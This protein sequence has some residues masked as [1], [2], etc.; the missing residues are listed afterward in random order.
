MRR[1]VYQAI[2]I[3]EGVE[4]SV[5]GDLITAKG[6][7]GEVRKKINLSGLDVKVEGSKFRVGCKRS[8]RN[9]KKMINTIEAHMKNMIEGVQK[10]FEYNLKICFSHF[11]I[12]T[13]IRGGEMIIKNFLGER[14]NRKAILPEGAEVKVNKEIIHSGSCKNED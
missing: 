1:E 9:E 8:T 2:E 13:E 3:P 5:N 4:I 7:Q 11:P 10:K 6:P 12:T 14:A